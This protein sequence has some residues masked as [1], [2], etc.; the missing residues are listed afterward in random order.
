MDLKKAM[1]PLIL[2]IVLIIVFAALT[3]ALT[4]SETL[5]EYAGKH[6]EEQ[7]VSPVVTP[8]ETEGA[9]A[10]SQDKTGSE[11]TETDEASITARLQAGVKGTGLDACIKETDDKETNPDISGG[12]VKGDDDASPILESEYSGDGKMLNRVT[13]TDG[14]FYEDIPEIIKDKMKGVSYPLD[15]DEDIICYDDLRYLNVLYVDFD[16]ETQVGE[17]V[18]NEAIAKDLIEIFHELYKA[19]YRIERIKL[20]DE[21]NADDNLSMEDNN[22]SSFCY[23]VVENTTRLSHHAYGRA[24]DINPFYN[25]YV[26]YNSEGT[27]ITPVGSEIYA[28]RS[29]AVMNPYRIDKNDLA[30]KLFKEHGFTWGGDW[31]SCKDYQHFEKKSE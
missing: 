16:G 19:D 6:P 29:D 3:R 13:L 8:G 18:C 4:G 28:D 30:Y 1:K 22:T 7:I 17:I 15:I 24:I 2:L 14:F 11:G 25:P 23:R 5:S 27:R 31:N 10:E 20:I 9:E 12:A 26:V 21:Y